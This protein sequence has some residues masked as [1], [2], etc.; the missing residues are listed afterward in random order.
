MKIHRV[1]IIRKTEASSSGVV[2]VPTA[3]NIKETHERFG[4]GFSKQ[5]F[6]HVS[7]IVGTWDT[8]TPKVLANGG[9][10]QLRNQSKYEGW[11]GWELH[12]TYGWGVWQ[13]VLKVLI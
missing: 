1:S 3:P 6:S 11:A 5:T 9:T 4:Y 7:R 13:L 10:N 8:H 12:F 2:L